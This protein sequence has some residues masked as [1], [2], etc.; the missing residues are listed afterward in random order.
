VK[1]YYQDRLQ[2]VVAEP[3]EL[4]EESPGSTLTAP[5]TLRSGR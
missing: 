2:A 5:S 1:L 3:R 4:L